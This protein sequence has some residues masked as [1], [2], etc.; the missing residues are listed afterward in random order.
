MLHEDGEDD[1][2]STGDDPEKD[3]DE[4]LQQ[5]IERRE[6]SLRPVTKQAVR[7]RDRQR[8]REREREG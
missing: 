6:K 5:A 3:N 8:R 7:K 1:A 4:K 2:S